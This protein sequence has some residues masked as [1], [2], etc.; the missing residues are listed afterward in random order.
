MKEPRLF[1]NLQD[2]DRMYRLLMAGRKANNGSYYIHQGDLKWWL[3]YPH[4]ERD[5]W[6][7]IYL[8]DDPEHS[9]RLLG[10][11][12]IS[13]DWVGFDVY[14]Q[15]E[16]RG[17]PFAQEMYIWAEQKA[18][19]IARQD[20]KSTVNVL[21]IFHD[22]DFLDSFLKQRGYR[23]GRGLVHM[24]RSLELPISP[25]QVSAGFEIRNCRGESEVD[26]RARAQYG[27]FKS[28]ATFERYLNRFT[29][30]M[31]SPVYDPELDIVAVAPDGQVGAF[32]I[33]WT[34]PL[35]QVGLFEPVGTH[36]EFQRKGLG[37]A[38]MLE[39]MHR[40]QE[41]GMRSAIVSTFEDNPPAI[42]LYESVGFQIANR[43]GTY[44]K[45]V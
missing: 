31:R 14:I 41:R 4:L 26:A 30:F 2:L 40:L 5:D 20:G 7:Y 11:A 39:A 33:V 27:A 36:P 17:S 16:L 38:V 42:K 18:L 23:C 29:N 12:L 3:Y 15:P 35:N 21:W 28:T 45:D 6:D 13:P 19:G 32:C 25:S 34:D 9:G 8:W 1:S 22:D 24:T 43:L 37:R 10:W 44:E